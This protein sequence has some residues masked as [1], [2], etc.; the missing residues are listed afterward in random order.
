VRRY[1]AVDAP[2]VQAAAR[3]YLRAAARVVMTV[4]PNPDAPIMGRVI[5]PPAPKSEVTK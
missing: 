4:E 3:T 1:R 2:A 5:Q